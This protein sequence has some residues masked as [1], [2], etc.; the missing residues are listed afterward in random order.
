LSLTTGYRRPM[1]RPD[2]LLATIV[3]A[4]ATLVAT[5]HADLSDQVRNAITRSGLDGARIAV[6]VR[7]CTSGEH[8]VSVAGDTPMIPASNM[9]LFTSGAAL[10]VLGPRFRFRTRFLH[11]GDRLWVAGDGD[12]AFGDPML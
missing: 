5:A 7:D 8:L 11:D 3:T 12:P 9:K 2:V 4:I 1:R 6:S 10:H